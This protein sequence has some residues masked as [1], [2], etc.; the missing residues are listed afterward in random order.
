MPRKKDRQS[1]SEPVTREATEEEQ[2]RKTEQRNYVSQADVPRHTIHE[3]LRVVRALA[4]EYG[5]Q[6]TRPLDVAAAMGMKPT[7]GWFKT[8]TGASV[9]YG[10]TDGGSQADEISLTGLARR[11]V[12]P[13][14]EGDDVAAMRE[15]LMQP[16]I[17]R[18]FLEKYDGSKL[19]REDI[20]RNVLEQMGVTEKATERTLN[21]IVKSADEL[22]LL[23]EIKGDTYVNLRSAAKPTRPD[24][25][26]MYD[27]NAE[28]DEEPDV[29]EDGDAGTTAEVNRVVEA[30]MPPVAPIPQLNRKVFISH[31]KNQKIV[32]QVK[33]L[34]AFGDF[35]PVVSVEKET[36]SKPVPDKVMDDMRECGA[37]IINVGS[38]KKVIDQQGEEHLILN[39][40]VLIEIGAA[41]ALYQGRF[42]LLVEKGVQLPS[43]LQGLYQVRY[44]GEELGGDATIKLLKAFNDFKK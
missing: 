38:E 44:A 32:D 16:R 21:L 33:E 26:L 30:V 9:A 10:F 14:E 4:D 7:T 41:M 28:D 3:A 24:A 22:G 13:T 37:G 6:P 31:G 35:E 39:Q 36:A 8:V 20:G 34:L 15:A 11:V 2:K 1:P 12:T 40:N 42:I 27:A 25:D 43:N 19:P 5:K 18:E 23:T 29:P 17:V